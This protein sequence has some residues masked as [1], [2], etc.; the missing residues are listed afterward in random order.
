VLLNG[1]LGAGKTL[2]A[3]GIVKGLGAEDSVSSPTFALVNVYRGRCEI[4]HFDLFRLNNCNELAD[5]GFFEMVEGDG[6]AIIEWAAKFATE[7]PKNS[8]TIT[9]ER[10][11]DQEEGRRLIFEADNVDISY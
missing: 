7:M 3:Q 1:D 6:V 10:L 9:L 8:I 2:L 5:I 4:Y 11:P